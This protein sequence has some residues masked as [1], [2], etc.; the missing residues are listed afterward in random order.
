M[1]KVNHI[2]FLLTIF[3]SGCTSVTTKGQAII[4]GGTADTVFDRILQAIV[5]TDLEV[6]NTDKSTG[7]I[8]A[9]KATASH[10]VDLKLTLFVRDL[11]DGT[12][13]DITSTLG[14]PVGFGLTRK[15][16][17]ELHQRMAVHL[18]QATFTIDG[19]PYQP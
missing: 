14:N 17:E 1:K 8:A 16:I 6:I 7:L 9:K 10:Q 12:V 2:I 13:V 5:E 4:S 11:P 15:V 18:P 19:K 3:L